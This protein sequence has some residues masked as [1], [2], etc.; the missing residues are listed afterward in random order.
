MNTITS[1]IQHVMSAMEA[2]PINGQNYRWKPNERKNNA[3]DLDIYGLT[4]ISSVM[5]LA[6]EMV[7]E[8]KVTVSLS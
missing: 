8:P 2:T 5:F 3:L 1:A 6:R 7:I 4:S